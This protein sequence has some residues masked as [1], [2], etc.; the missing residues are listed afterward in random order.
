MCWNPKMQYVHANVQTPLYFNK[1]KS[2]GFPWWL[3][4]LRI[5]LQCRRSRFHPW[6]EKTPWRREWQPTP[7]SCLGNPMDR[8]AWQ[9]QSIAWQ[10]VKNDWVTHTTWQKETNLMSEISL[11]KYTTTHITF[12]VPFLF[13]PAESLTNCM[14]WGH[15]NSTRQAFKDSCCFWRL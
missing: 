10:R 14:F 15:L 5:C 4:W 12:E 8:G 7:V 3:E 6:I 13:L 11:T 9:A 1:W 2:Y